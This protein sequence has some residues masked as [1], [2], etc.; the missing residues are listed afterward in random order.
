[1]KTVILFLLSFSFA[2]VYA[3]E[4]K[5]LSGKVTSD[6][7]DLE[8]IYVINK[9]ADRSITTTRG[10]YFTINAQ[11]NDTLI[12]SSIQ[13]N[14]KEVVVQEENFSSNLLFVPLQTLNRELDE[15]VI[16]DYSYIN[17]E[18]LGLV[19]K[20]QK[21]YT[22]AERKLATATN[23]KMNP[24]G[25]D[26]LINGLSGRTAM[27]KKAYETEK[28]EDLME[29]INYI[30][31]EESIVAQLKIPLEYV[32]GFIYFVVENKHVANAIKDKNETM[33]K[34]LM[35]GLAGKYLSLLNSND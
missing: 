26:P 32:R 9:N 33:A 7:D 24:M 10:G 14:A 25:L 22:P 19:P 15:L 20:G 16:V 28:K 5:P 12:F 31:T 4:R 35:S 8:G 23:Y 27:L 30:Y 17:S 1:L 29:K 6:F 21:Q 13:F 2:A 3:Q 34:F 11:V 18:S